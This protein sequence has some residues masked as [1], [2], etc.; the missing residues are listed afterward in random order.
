MEHNLFI[1]DWDDTIFPTSQVTRGEFKKLNKKG[2]FE[3]RDKFLFDEIDQNAYAL[4]HKMDR[5]G[6]I[7]IVT[8]ASESWFKKCLKTFRMIPNAIQCL[9]VSVFTV[10]STKGA[11]EVKKP[12]GGEAKTIN[13]EK[14][15]Q[16]HFPAKKIPKNAIVNIISIGDMHHETEAAFRICTRYNNVR[17]RCLKIAQFPAVDTIE[18]QLKWITD[19]V[20]NLSKLDKK[21]EIIEVK[22]N[23][24]SDKRIKQRE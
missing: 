6:S 16:C 3:N 5:H 17:A 23:L 14:A 4:F 2:I 7:S 18:Y 22:K 10:N 11:N 20:K 1:V 12:T 21:F 15:L 8:N 13:F 9:K 19:R 24:Y